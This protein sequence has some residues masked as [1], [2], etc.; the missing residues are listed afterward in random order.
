MS[1]RNIIQTSFDEFGKTS[2]GL[3]KSGSWYWRSDETIF[4][5]NL[6]KSQYALRYYVNVGLWLLAVGP[7]DAPTPSSCHI[8]NRLDGLVPQA[9]EERAAA[10][11]DLESPIDDEVRREELLTLLRQY[12][13][14]L[15]EVTSTLEGLRS[16]EGRRFVEV[17]L[18]DADGVHLLAAS[19]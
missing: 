3:K 16:G 19:Q 12:L 9:L 6:Q 15:M 13:L 5:V 7:A 10:L 2:G 17:S 14:P 18:V 11:L 8:Q 1:N 4:V